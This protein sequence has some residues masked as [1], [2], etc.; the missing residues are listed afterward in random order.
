MSTLRVT[1]GLSLIICLAW[2][3]SCE[4]SISTANISKAV[5]AKDSAGGEETAVFSQSDVFYCVVHLANAPD[6]TNVKAKWTA[7]NTEVAPPNTFITE[8]EID[9]GSAVLNFSLTGDQPWAIGEYKVDLYLDGQLDRSLSFQV[10]GASASASG[11]PATI[12]NASMFRDEQG[13][14]PTEV[15]DPSAV[16]YCLFDLQGAPSDTVTKSVWTAIQAEGAPENFVIG[17]AELT[18]GSGRHMFQLSL[19]SPWPLGRYKVD[20]YVNG[21]LGRTVEFGVGVVQEAA[22]SS[23]PQN[24]LTAAAATS[25]P[26]SGEQPSPNQPANPLAGGSNAADPAGGQPSPNQPANPLSGGSNTAD[27]AGEP[28]PAEQPAAEQPETEQPEV[29]SDRGKT[30][31]HVIGFSFWYPE[32]WNLREHDDFLQLVPPGEKTSP[33]GPEEIYV[34][35]GESV[36]QEG[37]QRAD[38]PRV[39][40]Y[41]DEVVRSFG[42]PLTRSGSPTPVSMAQGQGVLLEWTGQSP[43]GIALIARAYISIINEYG[44]ALLTLGAREHV[45]ARD[46]ELRRMFASFGFGEARRDQRLGGTWQFYTTYSLVNTSPFVESYD[47]AHLTSDSS[48]TLEFRADG[49]WK[50]VHWERFIAIG[51][52]ICIDS[53]DQVTTHKGRWFAD[54]GKLVMIWDDGG[55]EEHEYRFEQRQD[56]PIL[57]L[58]HGEKGEVWTP[59]SPE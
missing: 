54:D 1:A 48:T 39:A 51:S 16:F 44:V 53:G 50:R 34:I 10:V 27:P 59:Y 25:P 3:A 6:G 21:A 18:T 32:S 43:E 8:D 11:A 23:I 17:E 36:A 37:I 29:S 47:R 14:Q 19:P 15:F 56:G 40:Q 30:Y 28:A 7:V 24:P 4:V 31:R 58:S 55:W 5:L 33:Q 46:A 9:S 57:L 13:S 22:G 49:T 35:F 52:G 20:L 38:D 2:I 26:I 45:D 12:A 42:L 41:F